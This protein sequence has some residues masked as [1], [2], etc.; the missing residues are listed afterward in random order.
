VKSLLFKISIILIIVFSLNVI[1][2][3]VLII[4]QNYGNTHL[5]WKN[6]LEAAGH[7]VTSQTSNTVASGYEQVFDL[8]WSDTSLSNLSG[9]LATAYKTILANGGTVVLNGENPF[10]DPRNTTLEAFVRE[11]TGDNTIVYHD[12]DY[13][14][15]EGNNEYLVNTHSILDSL[16]NDWEKATW[17]LGGQI[18]D[19]GDDGKCLAQN[20][21]GECGVALWDGDALSSTYADGKVVIITDINYASHSEYY[22]ND[23]KDFLDALIADVITST[24]NTMSSPQSGITS[25]QQTIVT[26]TQATNQ[27]NNYIYITQSGS[28]IE[29]TI[30]QDGDD[31]LVI[32]P[33]LSAAGQI[34]GDDIELTITQTNDNN[35]IGI[36]IDG[37][38]ND[39][40]ITQNLNQSALIDITGASNTLNLNQT[41][42]SNQG[43]H[44]AKITIVG[45]SNVMDLDQTETGDKILFLDVD[46]SNNV[47]V[48][49]KGTGDMFLDITLT[50]GHTIDA[51]QDGSGDHSGTIDLSGNN[52]SVTLTQDS[53]TDQNYYLSQNCTQSSCSVTVTQN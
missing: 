3:D 34:T 42:L 49:Q 52:S 8:R 40:D 20:A 28:G 51:T 22:T 2:E 26:A 17:P 21:I 5:K 10:F 23:N 48:D 13:I 29:L 16:P 4:H 18:S 36:D 37:N 53:S 1:A 39:V 11:V 25:A 33:D 12:T 9:T 35:I 50:D 44:F 41:H 43:E 7:T 38:S 27:N 14:D 32:G 15:Y 45:S 31:N 19:L 47:T 6:R 30:T 46:S 24:L